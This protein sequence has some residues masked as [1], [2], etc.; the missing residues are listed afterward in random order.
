MMCIAMLI[1]IWSAH[2]RIT[3][4]RQYHEDVSLITTQKTADDISYYIQERKRLIHLFA[5][6]KSTELWS[7][8][9]N[10]DD[11]KPYND[12][13][14]ELKA[15]FPGTFT[16]T[17]TNNKGESNLIDFDN[18]MGKKCLSDLND[19]IKTDSQNIRIHPGQTYHF[20][21]IT[22]FRHKNNTGILFVS[23]N[24]DIISQSLLRAEIPGHLL[25]LTLPVENQLIEITSKGARNVW[26][27]D[28][29]QLTSDETGRI[30]SQTEV[31]N[32]EWAVIDLH[33]KTLLEEYKQ[34]IL[35]R[36]NLIIFILAISG[37]LFMVLNQHEIKR[38]Q[39]AEAA[40]DEF[41]SIVSH[42]LRTPL[43]AINGAITLINN[44]VTGEL[45]E[46]TKSIL[47]IADNN[48]HKLTLLVNDLLDVQ[49]LESRQMKYRRK[50]INPI[51]FVE[52]AVTDIQSGYFPESCSININNSLGN[53]LVFADSTRMEQ[54]INNIISN[55]VK[56]GSK[57]DNIDIKL[58]RKNGYVII[59]ITDYGDGINENT[60]DKI[61][62]KFT[63]TKMTDNRHETGSGLGLYIVKMI[64]EYHG[65]KIAYLSTPGKG[66]TFYIQLPI[67]II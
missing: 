46:K 30:L 26:I 27:R 42:E 51:K 43:T 31:E 23:F 18:L 33:D 52:S 48:T 19:F 64:I 54:V 21:I 39:K 20:D 1:I 5:M 61:F 24:T 66:T 37:L 28:S 41:L 15:Y 40:K 17:V 4:H 32:T 13:L 57:K 56:Y 3:E 60:K 29:Y 10:P 62:E 47:S 44:G 55:A 49:K 35:I 12:I 14:D 11:N 8:L 38:R 7:V 9:Q 50:L 63:Q 34:S 45:N 53:E 65:G 25:L 67:V 58:S 22:R 6:R 16:Y 36:G 2:T 59:A